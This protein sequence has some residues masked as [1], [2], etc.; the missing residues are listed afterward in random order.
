MVEIVN[1]NGDATEFNE[2][3]QHHVMIMT[4]IP[5]LLAQLAISGKQNEALELLI[6]WGTYEKVNSE[7]WSEAK[8]LLSA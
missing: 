5:E 2:L 4:Q 6:Q 3:V 1:G 8:Q 7:L